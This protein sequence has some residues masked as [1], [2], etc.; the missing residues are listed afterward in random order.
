MS[1]QFIREIDEE[2]RRDQLI[3][4]WERYGGYVIAVAVLIVAATAAWRGWDWYQ[5]REGV[6]AGS[7]FEAAV[8]LAESGKHAEAE[9]QFEALAK[10]GTWG[11]RLLSRMRLAAEIGLRDRA[12]G[13]AAYDAIAADT[14]VE[15]PVRDLARLSAVLLLLDSAQPSE[16]AARIEPLT[17]ASSPFRHQARETLALAHYRIGELD[18]ARKIFAELSAD[19]DTPPAVHSRADIMLS[20]LSGGSDTP[21]KPGSATQ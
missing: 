20:L 17:S 18:A 5:T 19:P 1:E 4:L 7:R 11:Y 2:L 3:K 12:A 15:A 14:S 6:K 8:A 21:A 16:I 13:A 10:D 9:Q